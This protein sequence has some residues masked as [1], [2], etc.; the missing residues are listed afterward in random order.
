MRLCL[1]SLLCFSLVG[2]VDA[3]KIPG[4]TN[5]SWGHRR[6]CGMC[7]HNYAHQYLGVPMDHGRSA[8]PRPSHA[9]VTAA[10]ATTT[11]V[12]RVEY[13]PRVADTPVS[14]VAAQPVD[15]YTDHKLVAY[16]SLV[17]HPVKDDVV[18]DLGCGDGRI[19]I[20]V[21]KTFK[22][23]C[24]G[25]E[26]DAQRAKAARANVTKAKLDHLVTIYTGDMLKA[27]I[28]KATIVFVYQFEDTLRKLKPQLDN[29]VN[30]HTVCS[31]ADRLPWQWS[32]PVVEHQGGKFYVYRR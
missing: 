16:M 5:Y 11:I 19:L 1:S 27:N 3:H 29:A 17:V 25:I 18:F 31:V 21:A 30:L 12:R 15:E 24:I 2:A 13:A 10:P 4:V 26:K 14:R 32:R 9:V 28:N 20:F 23:R 8:V 22:C 6:N 7:S